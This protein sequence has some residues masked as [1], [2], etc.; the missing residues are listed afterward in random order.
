MT[1]QDGFSLVEVLAATAIFALVSALSVGLL[2]G[3][4]RTQQQSEAVLSDLASVQRVAALLREDIGQIVAR[5]VRGPDGLDD[6]RLFAA[7]IH[8]VE[9]VRARAGD[10]REIIVLTRTGW[11]NP[12]RL[13]P[14]SN[15]QRV[16]WVLEDDRLYRAVRAYPDAAAGTQPRRQLLA[17]GV[18]EVE[19]ELVQDG[20]WVTVALVATGQDDGAITLPGAVRLSYDAPGLGRIEHVALSPTAEPAS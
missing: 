4:L 3:A 5:P 14:R 6:P 20:V 9:T 16:A 15:L 12:G 2:M 11:A 8:G 18:A 17:D 13:Q 19:L 7:N 1:R 10:A